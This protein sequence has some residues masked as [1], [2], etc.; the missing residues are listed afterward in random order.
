MLEQERVDEAK[1]LSS[2]ELS[3]PSRCV[4]YPAPARKPFQVRPPRVKEV[5][6]LAG[7]NAENY[8]GQLTKLLRS[9]IV[10]PAVTIIDSVDLTLGDRQ[11]LHVWVR[12]QIDP[13]YRFE[14]TCPGCG[15]VDKNY[16]LI[17][18]KIPLVGVPKGYSPNMKL[19][20]PRS[21]KVVTVRLETG[22]DRE[23]R[24]KLEEKGFTEWI[25]RSASVIT[26]VDG[27]PMDVE[28]RC[29]WLRGLPA[30]DN[31]FMGQYLKWQRHGPD[32]KNCPFKCTRCGKESV[33]DMPFRLEF[34]MPTVHAAS[35]FEDAVRGG[36][37]G[38]DG[39]VPGDA[40]D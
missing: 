14:T 7:M 20:L 35:T 38:A 40:S 12:A 2:V 19:T 37:V 32:F 36:G 4:D 24:D 8:D 31:L 6:F 28:A 26:T 15:Y 11:Y 27:E 30:G 39:G 1:N 9:L 17:I 21:K 29:E 16:K 33:L 5:E 10:S 3:L 25:A 34:Y 22:R 18:E 23:L 13:V